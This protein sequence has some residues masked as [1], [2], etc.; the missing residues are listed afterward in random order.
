MADH[1]LHFLAKKGKMAILLPHGG[2]CRSGIYACT[3]YFPIKILD[4]YRESMDEDRYSR[5]VSMEE[6]AGND[7]NL[8]ISR[9]VSTAREEEEIDLAKVNAELLE[10]DMLINFEK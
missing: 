6:I 8:N 9:Y 5:R 4:T 1:G 10:I 2:L 7:Y 3:L